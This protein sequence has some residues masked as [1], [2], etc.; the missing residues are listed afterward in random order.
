MLEMRD[1]TEKQTNEQFIKK[2]SLKVST[3]LVNHSDS[4]LALYTE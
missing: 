3:A 2:L 1:V 4:M